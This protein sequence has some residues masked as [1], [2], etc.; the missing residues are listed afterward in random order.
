MAAIRSLTLS[1]VAAAVLFAAGAASAAPTCQDRH[2]E[3]LRCG[4]PGAMPA[5]WA[6]APDQRPTVQNPDSTESVPWLG[7]AALVGGLFAM[8]ALMPDFDGWGDVEGDGEDQR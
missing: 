3:A 2:G 4:T 5:G 8:I 6:L 7:L 1:L